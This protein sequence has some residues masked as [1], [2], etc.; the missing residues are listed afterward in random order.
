MERLD[1]FVM[2]KKQ[3]SANYRKGLYDIQGI[4]CMPQA[5]WSCPTDWL[6]TI[7]VD[8]ASYG[9]SSRDVM[10]RL[11]EKGIQTRPLWNPLHKNL[12]YVG[13]ERFP[14]AEKLYEECLSLPSSVGLPEDDQRTVIQA[15]AQL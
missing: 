11:G 9:Q 3:I 15:L 5:S 2:M 13:S 14:V 8:E 4:E 12:P 6:F 7:R 10:K 1:E